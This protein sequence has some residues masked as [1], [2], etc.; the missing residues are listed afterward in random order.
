LK[1][2]A[3]VG[4]SFYLVD[5]GYYRISRML[6]HGE[7]GLW[8]IIIGP[9]LP[10]ILQFLHIFP[11]ALHPY[12]RII[13]SFLVNAGIISIAYEIFRRVV[14][15]QE[16]IMGL[17]IAIFN[18]LYV[19][20]CILR[21]SPELFIT[22]FLG[23]SILLYLKYAETGSRKYVY[24]L[25]LILPVSIFFK[26]VLFLIPLF[27]AAMF[28]KRSK[29]IV[30]SSLILFV[31]CIVF[32]YFYVNITKNPDNPKLSYRGFENII[33]IYQIESI[34]K[35]GRI[36]AERDYVF[37][38]STSN[39][40]LTNKLM[41]EWFEIYYK[42]H[43]EVNMIE[44]NYEFIKE[45]LGMFLLSKLLSPLFFISFSDST[46]K[47]LFNLVSNGLCIAA[48]YLG[49]R[50]I[51]GDKK[52]FAIF[53]VISLLGYYFIYFLNASYGR[54]G[55]PFVFLFTPFAGMYIRAKLLACITISKAGKRF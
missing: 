30:F 15:K 39:E 19:W 50:R 28:I 52:K 16:L 51:K 45:N 4:G 26:P 3:G 37:S 1:F 35:T 14:G 5:D 48:A 49:F 47:T 11:E 32:L 41:G 12:L 25:F 43:P 40:F 27:A 17:L 55:V 42:T 36:G 44:L 23:L 18:P 10:F 7:I 24:Y 6:F 54:Y 38:D 2:A 20:W 46:G 34:M 31:T 9:G 22:F 21:F 29:F 53:I 13:L 8:G 33:F